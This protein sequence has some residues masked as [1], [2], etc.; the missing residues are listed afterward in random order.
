M[1]LH[2]ALKLMTIPTLMGSVLT[3]GILTEK[4]TAV[5]ISDA[6]TLVNSQVACELPSNRELQLSSLGHPIQAVKFASADTSP[7]ETELLNFSEAESDAAAI[8]FGCDCPACLNSLRQL[9]KQPLFNNGNGRGHCWTSLQRRVSPQ[10]VQEVL[11]DLEARE[12]ETA[13]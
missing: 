3:L 4:A 13:P 12:A 6:P 1:N 11:Q 9:R 10:K 5:G 7:R 2:L 8:L